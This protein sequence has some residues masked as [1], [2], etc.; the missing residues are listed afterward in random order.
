MK[1][2]I[3]YASKYSAAGELAQCIAQKM[4]GA[5]VCNL[6]QG[7]IP[8]L[9]DFDCIIIG[10]SLYA[11]MIRPEAK[12]FLLKYADVLSGKKLGL[13]LSGIGAEGEKTYFENNF[14]PDILQKVKVK[15]FLGGIFDPKKAG[16]FE[17]LIIKAVAKKSAYINIID[18]A[19]IEQF[20]KA[21]KA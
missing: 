2:L 3:L 16:V 12:K 19:K 20:V 8:A 14:S 4:D 15:S 10:S 5:L 17:R 6:K 11:G 7:K 13:F 9:A 21:M 18:D 1:T